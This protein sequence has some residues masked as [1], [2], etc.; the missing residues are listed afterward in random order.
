MEKLIEALSQFKPQMGPHAEKIRTKIFWYAR[1]EIWT[2]W[3]RWMVYSQ[4]SGKYRT[5]KVLKPQKDRNLQTIYHF[6]CLIVELG[7]LLGAE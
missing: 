5:D 7:N 3:R 6:I 1:K 4:T 2:P